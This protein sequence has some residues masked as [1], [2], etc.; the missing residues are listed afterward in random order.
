MRRSNNKKHIWEETA[1]IYCRLS[2]DD[3]LE[4]ESYSIANQDGISQGVFLQKLQVH[5]KVT[6][7]IMTF[8]IKH[9]QGFAQ[10]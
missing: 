10:E 7:E 4:G 2:R 9:L 6:I 5:K 3:D 1:I 8:N